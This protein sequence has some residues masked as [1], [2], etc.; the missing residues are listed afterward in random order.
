MLEKE[1]DNLIFGLDIGT[2]TII[3][4]VGYKQEKEFIVV[5][6]KIIEH[7]SR[8]MVDGQ[9]HDILAVARSAKKVKESLE[10]QIGTVLEEVSIAA[11][12]RVLKTVKVSVS[13]KF[14]EPQIINGFMIKGLELQGIQEAQNQITETDYEE[15]SAYFYVG[16]SVVNYYLNGYSI[17]NLEEQKGKE[18][19]ADILATFLPKV[20]VD[21]LYTVM[22]KIG[23]KVINITLEP[24]AAMNAVIPPN[25]RLLNLALVD[26]GAGTSDIA[27]TK[28]GSVMAYGMIPLAGDAITEKLVH[29]YLVDFKTAENIK[30]QLAHKATIEFVD[31]IGIS[32][33]VSTKDM[34]MVIKEVVEKLGTEIASKIIS[35]NGNSPPNAVFCVGGASQTPHITEILAEKLA[36]PIER[37]SIRSSQHA[38]M[39]ID[40]KKEIQGPE[41]ITPLGICLTTMAKKENDF[42][43][44]TV[45]DKRVELLHTKKITISDAIIAIGMDHTQ[46]ISIRGKTLMFKLNGKRIRIKGG[47]GN[48]PRIICNNKEATLETGISEGDQL[49]IYPAQ[50]GEDGQVNMIELVHQVGLAEEEA[51]IRVNGKVVDCKYKVQENDEIVIINKLD[52]IKEDGKEEVVVVQEEVAQAEKAQEKVEDSIVG[53]PGMSERRSIHVMVNDEV[54]SI[55]YKK[56]LVVVTVFDFIDFDLSSPQGNIVLKQNGQ[57]AGYTDAL[58]DG[59]HIEI[60]WDKKSI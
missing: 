47:V 18:I 1:K 22:D 44:I 40:D 3:G 23:L 31:I 45:N 5:A 13:Q 7:E 25:L 58:K 36:L 43:N 11:A 4:I 21:S 6:T 42:V 54:I 26:I 12:G 9:I 49:K 30:Q 53:L 46:I 48:Q 27:I 15:E 55:P 14:D 10:S 35:L 37:V 24:I 60:Y 34:Q 20:V 8:A 59:D 29:T 19:G 33:E 50:N 32:H 17:A 38:T 41:S 39:V 52:E 56:N 57:R 16:H 2:R 51:R 28:E